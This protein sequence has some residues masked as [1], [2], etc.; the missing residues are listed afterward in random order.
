LG[1]SGPFA[2]GRIDGLAAPVSGTFGPDGRFSLDGGCRQLRF[3]ALSLGNARLGSETVRLC[4]LAGQPLLAV[5]VRGVTGGVQTG[6]L[7]LDGVL[8]TSPMRLEAAGGR[9]AFGRDGALRDVNLTIGTGESSLRL[10]A[11]T[12][13]LTGSTGRLSGEFDESRVRLGT[14]PFNLDQ[15]SG[16]WGYANGQLVVDGRL[17]VTDIDRGDGDGDGEPDAPRFEPMVVRD[18]RLTLAD[19]RIDAAGRL[20]NRESEVAVADVELTHGLT[21]GTGHAAFTLVPIR[22]S[23]AG[24][25]PFTLS[26]LARGVVSNVDGTVNGNGR[27]DWNSDRV[28]S[29][30]S[31]STSNASMAAAFGPVQGLT[32]TIRFNDLI[33]LSTPPGQRATIASINPGIEVI[34]G[35]VLYQLLPNQ[36][37]RLESGRWPFAG[38]LLRLHPALLDFAADRPRQLVFDVEGIDAARFLQRYGFENISATGVFD[39]V[40]PTVFDADGGRV[41]GGSLVVRDGG[42]S[43][44]YVGELTNRE[45]GY[46]GNLAFGALRS[47]RYDSLV[48]RLNGNIDGEMLTEVSFVG[49]GQGPGA[50][51][52]FLTRQIAQLPFAFNIRINAPFR[53]LLTSARSLYDPTILIDQNLPALLRAEAEADDAARARLAPSPPAS[54]SLAPGVQQQESGNQP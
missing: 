4:S 8:G 50:R 34:D 40:L 32:G 16:N 7:A 37:V 2:G 47:I 27:I 44:A 21:S 43:L 13:S 39:G 30:G 52:N 46:F 3:S 53:Q 41:E 11:Q 14:I 29:V 25:Q 24:L 51:N 22:F 26:E 38:G 17:D 10:A 6:P 20:I 48:I 35:E 45:L 5:D 31:F 18:A 23:E 9:Y 19:G 49:L 36:Q 15:M 42:G 33:G 1:A 28:T 12:L 54:Q